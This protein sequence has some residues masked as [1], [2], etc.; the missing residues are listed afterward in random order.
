MKKK[1]LVRDSN[2]Y[3]YQKLYKMQQSKKHSSLQPNKF[4][5]H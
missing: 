4:Q 2:E 5:V 1:I 3:N